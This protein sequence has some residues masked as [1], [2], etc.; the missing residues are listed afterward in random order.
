MSKII[1][2]ILIFI[3]ANSIAQGQDSLKYDPN[4][5]GDWDVYSFIVMND[6]T[7]IDLDSVYW[8]VILRIESDSIEELLI[9]TSRKADLPGFEEKCKWSIYVDENRTWIA[10]PCGNYVKGEHEILFLTE[11]R[12]YTL[13]ESRETLIALQFRRVDAGKQ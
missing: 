2:T 4:L 6:T 1:L 5:I 9:P 13:F 12:L 3:S 8:N 10:I 11:T 7:I